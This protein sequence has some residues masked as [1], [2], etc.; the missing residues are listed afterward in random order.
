MINKKITPTEFAVVENSEPCS[1]HTLISK[2]LQKNNHDLAKSDKVASFCG[3]G[4]PG[5]TEIPYFENEDALKHLP[6]LR[7]LG[8][9][10]LT[11]VYV[12]GK[13]VLRRQYR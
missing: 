8:D 10:K 5:Q 2:F 11:E 7:F 12:V 6:L 3:G 13:A 1:I 9:D 4:E